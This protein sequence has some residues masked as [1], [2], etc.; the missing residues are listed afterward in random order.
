M[1]R[2]VC[3]EIERSCIEIDDVRKLDRRIEMP[4]DFV[5]RV[6]RRPTTITTILP[7]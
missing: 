3:E 5:L 2:N 6:I 7:P 1:L 4:D